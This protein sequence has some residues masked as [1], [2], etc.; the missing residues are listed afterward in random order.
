[1]VPVD[2]FERRFGIRLNQHVVGGEAPLAAPAV[3]A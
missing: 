1:M 2:E 3:S